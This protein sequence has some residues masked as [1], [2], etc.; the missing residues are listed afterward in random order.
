MVISMKLSANGDAFARVKVRPK[1]Y[2][3]GF[4]SELEAF[5]P[6]PDIEACAVYSDFLYM[7][8]ACICADR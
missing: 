7:I 2:V 6:Q 5:K 3:R 4:S 1:S 8:L